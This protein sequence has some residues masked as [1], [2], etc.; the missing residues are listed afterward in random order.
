MLD[1][2]PHYSEDSSTS[3]TNQLKLSPNV[4]TD[5]WSEGVSVNTKMD[6]LP[7]G[8]STFQHH[9]QHSHHQESDEGWEEVQQC[10]EEGEKDLGEVTGTD[11]WV[12]EL[13]G[14]AGNSTFFSYSLWDYDQANTEDRYPDN[15]HHLS[16]TGDWFEGVSVNTRLGSLRVGLSTS[17]HHHQHFHRQESEEDWEEVEQCVEEGEENICDINAREEEVNC[18]REEGGKGVGR[19]L[20]E[21]EWAGGGERGRFLQIHTPG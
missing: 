7:V 6:P 16:Q 20:E 13:G 3:S 14:L 10:V 1:H 4:Q 21:G 11:S 9:H 18:Q 17:H 12:E 8:L 19:Q 2:G 5:D 15:L